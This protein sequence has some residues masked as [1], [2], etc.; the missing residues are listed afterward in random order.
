[1][2]LV[3]AILNCPT[4]WNT[5][6]NLLDMGF[7]RYRAQRF[8]PRETVFSVPVENGVKKA[9]SAAPILAILYPTEIDGGETYTVETTFHRIRAPVKA[10]DPV[11]TA[12]LLR[13]GTVVSTVPIVALESADT[14]DLP[15]YLRK[16]VLGFLG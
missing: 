16:T 7:S 13:N 5:A 9:L 2:K 3:G 10:G 12:S 8:L 6:K 11:G 1:M 14:A 15:Y 4:M